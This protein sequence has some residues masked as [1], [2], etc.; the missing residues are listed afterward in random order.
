MV[1]ISYLLLAGQESTLKDTFDQVITVKAFDE[2]DIGV[3]QMNELL[4][5]AP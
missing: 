5:T 4:L 2:G 1:E 3:S